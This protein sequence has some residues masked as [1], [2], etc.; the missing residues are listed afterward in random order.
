[1][2]DSVHGAES[3]N[4]YLAYEAGADAMLA[5]LFEMARNSPTGIFTIDGRSISVYRLEPNVT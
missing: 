2:K 1:M 5:A 3:T 4:I